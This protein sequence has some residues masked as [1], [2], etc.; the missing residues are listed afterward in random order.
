MAKGLTIDD[1]MGA[2]S[3]RDKGLPYQEMMRIFRITPNQFAKVVSNIDSLVK[4]AEGERRERLEAIARDQKRKEEL[5]NMGEE[6]VKEQYDRIQGRIPGEKQ[7]LFYKGTLFHH[8]NV[9]TIV[10][11]A[12]TLNNPR[13][14]S[15]NRDEVI[16]C[17]KKLPYNLQ[18]Y[19]HNLGLSG[20][21]NYVFPKGKR[22]SPLAVLKIFDKVYREKTGDKSL[23]YLAQKR[24][25]KV[26]PRNRL[27]RE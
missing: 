23:F 17:I 7:D 2:I 13:L 19:L 8:K 20:L 24:Y 21:M 1:Y 11:Y 18:K 22:N 14:L 16:E 3:S 26:G 12:L 6:F 5:F 27:I 9:E 15:T 4:M 10:Y 25:L